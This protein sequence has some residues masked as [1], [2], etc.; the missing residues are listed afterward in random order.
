MRNDFKEM[1]ILEDGCCQSDIFFVTLRQ[2]I[3]R[4]QIRE[5]SSRDKRIG[6]Q[7]QEKSQVGTRK[8]ASRNE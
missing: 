3:R 5:L 2:E 6:E 8:L 1:A 7:E 4:I